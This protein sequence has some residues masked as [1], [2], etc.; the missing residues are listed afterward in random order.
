[1][2]AE[3]QI[4]QRQVIGL[5][6]RQ[7]EYLRG[8]PRQFLNDLQHEAGE[9]MAVPTADGFSRHVAATINHA[10]CTMLLDGNPNGGQTRMIRS[11]EV[12]A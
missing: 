8:K 10:C 11:L 3:I 9:I 5:Y 4:T 1:M 6:S 12:V 2:N 7:L